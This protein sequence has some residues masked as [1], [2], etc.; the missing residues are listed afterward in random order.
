LTE[1]EE[2]KRRERRVL[3]MAPTV[4]DGAL[5][6]SLLE[7][8]DLASEVFDDLS[9][10]CQELERGA[11]AIVLPEEAVAEGGRG[12]VA[13]HVASQ[14]PWSDLPI[15]ILARPGA[16]SADVAEA[17][18]ML[19]NV[20]VLERPMRV[21][22]LVSALRS[23][24]RARSRQY[25]IRDHLA[26][27]ERGEQLVRQTLD[28][29]HTLLEA[30]P[31]GVFIAHDAQCQRVTGNRAANELLRAPRGANLSRSAPDGPDVVRFRIRRDGKQMAVH[32]LPLQRAARGER[33]RSEALEYAFD[34]GAVMHAT[35]SAMPLLDARGAPRGA[36]G[37]IMDMTEHKR[38]EAVLRDADRRKDEFLAILAHE[39]R[40]PLAPIRNS[41][42]LL[43]MSSD[44]SAATRRVSEMMERQ[45]DLM[46]RLVDDL[47]EVSR[48]TRGTISLRTETIDA[49]TVV[50]RSIEASRALVEAAGHRL[51]LELPDDP[52]YVDADA[53]RL[54]QVIANLVNNA[55]KY[56]DAGGEVRLAMQRRDGDCVISVCDTGVGID[57]AKLPTVFDL[58]MQI[59]P[60]GRRAQGG[61]GIGL[62]LVKRLVEMHGGRV[63][64]RSEGPNRGSEFI[65][66]LPL[67]AQPA[68][69]PARQPV[70]DAAA[71]RPRRV[72]I[73]DDNK[74]AGESLAMLL[75][76][77]G[78]ESRVERSGQ[79]ALDALPGYLP[80]VVILDIGM[81]GMDGHEVARRIRARSEFNDVVLVALTGWGQAEDRRRSRLAGFD[82]H[83]TKPAAL[84]DLKRLLGTVEDDHFHAPLG[85]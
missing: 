70:H 13:R 2:R 83:L 74:D 35:V 21:A 62:T 49:G 59:N 12:P 28:E 48:I 6:R 24:V 9:R 26:E 82:H 30:L 3:V 22:A 5:T 84:D 56:T 57:A 71:A 4:R 72:L 75:D 38:N 19:G 68:P 65:V 18:E 32:E 67:A 55:A 23:A 8:A 31:I 41:L 25:Q 20:T 27:R 69:T 53:A 80:S 46:V 29:M 66:R 51:V 79:D 81:P 78:I 76:I 16:V 37:A 73:V 63:E 15:L 36:V 44:V 11:A 1:E 17:M 77:L 64:A 45:V 14:P 58:F 47:L 61:L 33:V 43:R 42:H 34:D 52:V 40:N 50:R 10:L 54:E 60:H 39:L 7:R 85:A